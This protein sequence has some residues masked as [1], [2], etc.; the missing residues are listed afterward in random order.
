MAQSPDFSIMSRMKSQRAL[1]QPLFSV[2]L[3]DSSREASEVTFGAIKKEHY[4]GDIF[5]ADVTGDTGYWEVQIEDITIDNQKMNICKDCKAAVDT[6]TSQL[7]GPSDVV[8]SLRELLKIDSSCL[9]IDKMPNLGFVIGGRV[10]NL[11][12]TDYLDVIG[13]TD[14]Q[15]CNLALMSLDVPP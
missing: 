11:M 7:A 15:T 10:L 2:F 12:P 13:D 1:K 14:S 9:G 4:D 8:Q 5:W 3:S 6:G